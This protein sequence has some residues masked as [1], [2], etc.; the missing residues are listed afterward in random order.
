MVNRVAAA[1]TVP[2]QVAGQTVV[3]AGHAPEQAGVA[4][5]PV[6]TP[7]VAKTLPH[8]VVVRQTQR[9]DSRRKAL[10]AAVGTHLGRGVAVVVVAPQRN[11]AESQGSQLAEVHKGKAG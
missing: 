9:A 2:V 8:Q 3:Y 10:H 7:L 1:Q 5:V 11:A 4:H 6:G